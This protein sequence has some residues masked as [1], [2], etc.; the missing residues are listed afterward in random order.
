M[1]RRPVD[2]AAEGFHDEGAGPA[3]T[4]DELADP[5]NQAAAEAFRKSTFD[6]DEVD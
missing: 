4:D 1:T 3:D 5:D 2:D 6:D